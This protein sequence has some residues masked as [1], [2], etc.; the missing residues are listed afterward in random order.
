MK[1]VCIVLLS[2]FLFL[3]PEKNFANNVYEI[4]VYHFKDAQQEITLD[5]YLQTA[6]LPALHRKDKKYIGVFKPIANDTAADKIIYV[7]VPFKSLDEIQAIQKSL[8]KDN[9]Y[10]E[11]GKNYLTATYQNP[12]YTRIEKIVLTAFETAPEIILP[13]LNADKKDHIYELRSYE[14]PTENYHINKVKMF[15]SGETNI[16][17]RLNCNPVFYG[18]VIF[19]SHIPNL[20]YLTSYENMADRDAHWK[21]F[22][23]D[24]QWKQLSGMDEYKN[25]VSKADV[26]L[27]H[28]TS[29]SDY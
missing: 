3:I 4:T 14:S 28:A 25:N 24:P 1:Q 29:Y 15:N 7:I 12:P 17:T 19:G 23:D 26:I 9:I 18:D 10:M 2:A 27:M 11:A 6:Y 22:S 5:T 8:A 13:K 21:S 16:F 20:M